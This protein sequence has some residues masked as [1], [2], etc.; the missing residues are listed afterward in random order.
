MENLK[1]E[2]LNKIESSKHTIDDIMW[3][4]V[5]RIEFFADEPT[6]SILKVNHNRNELNDFINS[7]DYCYDDGYGTQEVYGEIVFSDGS[8]LERHEYDGS[9]RW[10]LKRI[11]S[12]P[13]E[14]R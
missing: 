6:Y 1:K 2:T 3:A 13:K 9:E 8:W 14:C 4:K 11:P 10:A 5:T 7:L 12:I